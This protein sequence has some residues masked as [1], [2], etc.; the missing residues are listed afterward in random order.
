MFDEGFHPLGP[1][2]RPALH[3]QLHLACAPFSKTWALAQALISDEE[4][5]ATLEAANALV[6][7][8]MGY[9]D[10]GRTHALVV[11]VNALTLLETGLTLGWEPSFGKREKII[12]SRSPAALRVKDSSDAAVITLLGALMHDLGNS[13]SRE[14]HWEYSAVLA[15]PILERLLEPVYPQP[16]RTKIILNIM[17]VI[18]T[19]D[20][21]VNSYSLEGSIVKLADAMD[22]EEGRSRLSP[23]SRNA[24]KRFR[25][26]SMAIDFVHLGPIVKGKPLPIWFE[27]ND[28]TGLFQMDGVVAKRLETSVLGEKVIAEAFIEG[29]KVWKWPK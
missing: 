19:H 7:N 29:K 10:H 15:R 17:E 8:R 6:V 20:H 3:Q 12:S 4:Y 13:V 5:D 14:R 23:D 16:L 22:C 24:D 9:S 25:A 11:A 2:K 21:A 27:L 18:H 26:S 28:K 1:Q